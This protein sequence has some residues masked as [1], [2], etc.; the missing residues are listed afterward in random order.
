MTKK[1]TQLTDSTESSTNPARRKFVKTVAAGATSITFA[2]PLSAAG[3]SALPSITS[4]L[5]EEELPLNVELRFDP[6]PNNQIQRIK[7]PFNATRMLIATYGAGGSGASG[8]GQ[9][10]IGAPGGAGGGTGGRVFVSDLSGSE[11]VLHIG[12]GAAA[13][14]AYELSTG[15]AF[16]GGN[17]GT[18][19]FGGRG[20]FHPT[21]GGGGGGYTAVFNGETVVMVGGGGG[22]GG[23][24]GSSGETS[25]GGGGFAQSD[26]AEIRS[27]FN[28]VGLGQGEGGFNDIGGGGG[29][30]VSS[31]NGANGGNFVGGA[32]GD[33]LSSTLYIAGGA[34]GGGGAGYKIGIPTG[35]GG[36]G[37]AGTG[38]EGSDD[39]GGGGGAGGTNYYAPFVGGEPIK[40]FE[41][42]AGGAGGNFNTSTAA[43]SGADGWVEIS[44]YED[45]IRAKF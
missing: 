23:G 25:G 5:L 14:E 27:G 43:E 36:G 39:G 38:V 20:E 44:F 45:I 35:G 3:E 17:G 26:A 29:S 32:G 18:T 6:R 30:A 8:N 16:G 41:G 40:T 19:Q 42:G 4:L 11:L 22:G 12:E 34:G 1:P 21:F 7:V 9:N 10:I 31:H 28:A 37:G 2:K 24:A 15:G 13:G 33:S